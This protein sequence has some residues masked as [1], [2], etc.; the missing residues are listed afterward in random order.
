MIAS[1]SSNFI[2]IKTRKTAGTSVEIA[3]S[4]WC[5]LTDI[6]TPVFPRDELI[7]MG[8]GGQPSNFG[9]PS[10][11]RNQYI[12]A[13]IRGDLAEIERLHDALRRPLRESGFYGHMP[14]SRVR[15]LLP[16]LWDSAFKFT[17]ERHP[18]E[19]AVSR[20]F[21]W[22]YSKCDSRDF[23]EIIEDVVDHPRFSDRYL[24][25]END[26]L[27]VDRIFSYEAVW[28]EISAFAKRIGK[29]LPDP[30]P[31]AKAFTRQDRRPA[32]EILSA[33]QKRKIRR[34]CAFEI[35]LMN[36]LV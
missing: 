11:L 18:Y 30:L 5:G 20:A 13:V 1:F 19:K 3:I 31:Q 17:I 10:D 36:F 26:K 29:D 12:N 33:E 7:R 23:R 34:K 21:W 28:S 14:A 27:L 15:K 9:G 24:Y 22:K 6:V 35:E 8:Y 4:P 2:F 16:A 25:A 32:S